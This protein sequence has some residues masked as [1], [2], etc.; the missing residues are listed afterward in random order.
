MQAG[1][2]AV[3]EGPVLAAN[4]LAFLNGEPL[5]AYEPQVCARGTSLAVLLLLR[6][7]NTLLARPCAL[8]AHP[9]SMIS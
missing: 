2:Y 5:T 4:M 3:R 9:Y 8:P 1:V 7:L 6:L